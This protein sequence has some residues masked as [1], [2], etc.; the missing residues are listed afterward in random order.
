MDARKSVF[1][2]ESCVREYLG[3]FST[4]QRQVGDTTKTEQWNEANVSSE[5][6][7]AKLLHLI[8]VALIIARF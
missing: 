6:M 8:T 7:L 3:G 5:S 1:W 2:T 4:K